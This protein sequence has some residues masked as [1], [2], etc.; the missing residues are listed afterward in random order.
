MFASSTTQMTHLVRWFPA[1]IPTAYRELFDM[2]GSPYSRNTI[3]QAQ[4]KYRCVL[5]ASPDLLVVVQEV[6]H[7]GKKIMIPQHKDNHPFF[8]FLGDLYVL[9]IADVDLG[10]LRHQI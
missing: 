2:S 9:D 6:V 3:V 1:S 5:H 7:A 10:D 8:K 4:I